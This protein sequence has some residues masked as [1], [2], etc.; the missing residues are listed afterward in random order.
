MHKKRGPAILLVGQAVLGLVVFGLF[1]FLAHSTSGQVPP[2]YA[3]SSIA[4]IT[5]SSTNTSALF[6]FKRMTLEELLNEDVTSVSRGP[7]PYKEAPASL[8][9]VNS[10]D[11][12]RAGASSIPEALRLA[13]NLEVAQASSSTWNI[14]ARGFNGTVANKLLV[15]MDGRSVYTPLFSGVIWNNQD[16]LLEDLDRIEVVSGPGG[17]L[18]GAN[19]VNGVINIIS[20]DAKDTQGA[21]VTAGGGTWLQDFVGARYGGTLGSNV[22]YRVYGKYFDRGSQ[23]YADGSDA[24]DAWNRGQGG[25]R[26]DAENSPNNHLTLDGGGYAGR[27]DVVPGGQGSPRAV[28]S[29]SGGHLLGRWTHEIAEESD[30]TWQLYYDRTHLDAPFQG[31]GA[32]PP[33]ALK[34]DLDTVDLDFQHRFALGERQRI[35]WG[36][37][38]RFTHDSVREAPLVAFLP[39][40]LD[41][42][43][44]SG[45]VQD[46]IKIAEPLYFTVGTKLEHYDYTGFEY[47]PSARL[48]WNPATNH[49]IWAAVSR[50]VRT[51]SRYDRDLFEPAPPY[52]TLLV[53]NNS[54]QSET[55]LAYELGY[56]AQLASKVSASMSAFYNDYG[57]L[58]SLNLTSGGLPVHFE[59]HLKGDTYGIE[60]SATYQMLPWW[61]LHAGYDLLKETIVVGPQGDINGGLNETADPQNQVFLRSSMDLGR[62]VEWDA[63]LRWID[64]VHNNNGATPGIVPSY[65]EL[66]MRLG[67]HPTK[68][69]ELSLVGQNLIHDQHPEAG[70]PGPTQE[71]IVRSVYGSVTFRW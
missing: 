60:L 64:E 5:E 43:L 20:K 47:E 6:Q 19:A 28:G 33:G 65:V 12:R 52:G 24:H 57:R 55:V 44:F 27:N 45:F 14:S 59:N 62:S 4:G 17:T 56:R 54:F 31:A 26:I 68:H 50:A 61:R 11:I 2:D 29:S 49:M 53:G 51:P 69:W 70:F 9:V 8:V 21:Y 37:E 48:Q 35:V 58:R 34:D 18:W 16:Y 10:E 25:F 42:N 38:Y 39:S 3:S 15:L 23:V 32:I 71:E 40:T 30:M 13:D 63:N 46:E 7:E 41:Q 36:L 67:W 22:Y 66:D 1:S